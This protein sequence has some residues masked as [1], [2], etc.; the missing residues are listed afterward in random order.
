MSCNRGKCFEKRFK[1]FSVEESD[2]LQQKF[3]IR[4]RLFS[5]SSL[6]NLC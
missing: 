4:A 1:S 3:S 5:T 6:V 2:D